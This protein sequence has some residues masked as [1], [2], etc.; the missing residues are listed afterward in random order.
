[1]V[2]NG[3]RIVVITLT[4]GVPSNLTIVGHR[5]LESYDGQPLTCYGC[6]ET[7]HIYQMCPKRRRAGR[8]VEDETTMS[9]AAIVASGQRPQR[10]VSE[11]KREGTDLRG[12]QINSFESQRTVNVNVRRTKRTQRLSVSAERIYDTTRE[13]ENKPDMLHGR[14]AQYATAGRDEG[15]PHGARRGEIEQCTHRR[16]GDESPITPSRGG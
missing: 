1:M 13:M 11:E 3:I 6:G 12:D 4:K 2:A 16:S 9:W 14:S 15:D 10:S 5:V 8:A 7:G